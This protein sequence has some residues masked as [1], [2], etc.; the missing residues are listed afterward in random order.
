MKT[1]V[2]YNSLSGNGNGAVRAEKLRG[3]WSDK[4]LVYQDLQQEDD[5]QA[6][7]ARIAPEDE[8]VICGGDGT[9]NRFVNQIEGMQIVNPIY[10]YPAGSGNDFWNDLGRGEEDEPVRLEPYVKN[11]PIVVVNGTRQRFINGI[12][13]GIDGYCC[14]AGDDLRAKSDKPIN[15]TGIAIKGMLFYYKPTHAEIKVDGEYFVYDRVWLAPT[16][17]GRF[18]GGGMMATPGQDRLNEAGTVTMMTMYGKGKL[19][20]LMIFPSIFKGEHVKHTDAVTVRS[21]KEVTV[22]FDRPVALQIDGETV[23]SVTEY[24]VIAGHP[25]SLDAE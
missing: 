6:L 23:R 8:V 13:Y 9:L 17:N 3:V 24:T 10:Y 14:E 19:G 12:G 11:L 20:T 22:K 7:F 16:M 15:Y 1:Y 21:G 5:Y 25:A 4:D 18:Y 2:M